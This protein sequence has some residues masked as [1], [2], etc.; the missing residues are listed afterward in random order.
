MRFRCFGDMDAPDWILAE[1]SVLAKI[2]SVRMKI[3]VTQVINSIKGQTMD[4]V[5]LVKL[6]GDAGLVTSEVKAGVGAL[7]HILRTAAQYNCDDSVLENELQQLGLPREHTVSVCR[8][9]KDHR[10]ALRHTLAEETLKL[11]GLDG[12][13]RW[14]AEVNLG[15]SLCANARSLSA[16]LA[17]RTGGQQV[18]FEMSQDQL[19]VLHKELLTARSIMQTL[20]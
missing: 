5:K 16:H 8:P 12:E 1:I 6:T 11:P 9:Y 4:Y 15:S 7:E 3:I 2:S 18:S 20:H 19:A 10:Q 17:L 13:P 14:R